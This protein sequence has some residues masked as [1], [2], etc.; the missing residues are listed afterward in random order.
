M[1]YTIKEVTAADGYQEWIVEAD[2]VEEAF[3]RL[4]RAQWPYQ[5]QRAPLRYE[6]LPEVPGGETGD[7]A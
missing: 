3:V 7:D 6:E 5:A 4:I 2:S 1:K